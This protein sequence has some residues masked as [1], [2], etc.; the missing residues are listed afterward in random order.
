MIATDEDALICDF[1]ETYGIFGYRE[2]PVCTAATLAVGLRENSRI[3]IKLRDEKIDLKTMLLASIADRL[4]TLV[5]FQSKDG[6]EGINRPISIVAELQKTKINDDIVVFTSG[7][8]FE[9][10]R[11]RLMKG[12]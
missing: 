1:A 2:L 12:E 5:W 10:E 7:E 11:N 4:G 9:K 6:R 3:K 8:D